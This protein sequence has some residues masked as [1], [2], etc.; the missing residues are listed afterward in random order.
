MLVPG[1]TFS[2]SYEA[3]PRAV[4]TARRA[5]TDFAFAA[6]AHGE[7]LQAVRLAASEAVTNVVLHAYEPGET[8]EVHV[9]ASCIDGELWVLVADRGHGQRPRD[10]SPGLGLGLAL[11]ARLAD[12][13]VILSRGSGGT[14][15]RMRFDLCPGRADSPVI[16]ERSGPSSFTARSV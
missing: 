15:V 12:D 5:L 11:I 7:R 6:G 16:G 14:E 4:P 2:A 13:L 1:E 10:D 9:N 8:G 3:V